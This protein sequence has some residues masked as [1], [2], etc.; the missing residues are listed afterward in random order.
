MSCSTCS[1]Y[2]L[3]YSCNYT[4]GL[5]HLRIALPAMAIIA[6]SFA[7]VNIFVGKLLTNPVNPLNTEEI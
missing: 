5:D 4:D 1:R 2:E 3:K 7:I 6:N